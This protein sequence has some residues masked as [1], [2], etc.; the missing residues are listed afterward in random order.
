MF[1]LFKKT[2]K[3]SSC[4]TIKIEEVKDSCCSE[5]KQQDSAMETDEEKC[6]S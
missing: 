5:T 2:G 6:C 4:C 3:D 1:N